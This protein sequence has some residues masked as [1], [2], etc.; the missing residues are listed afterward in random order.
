MLLRPLVYSRSTVTT[1]RQIPRSLGAVSTYEFYGK[2]IKTGPAL[3]LLRAVDGFSCRQPIPALQQVRI[4]GM[5]SLRLLQFH[6]PERRAY[7]PITFSADGVDGAV[8]IFM[9]R[10]PIRALSAAVSFPSPQLVQRGRQSLALFQ[11]LM[12]FRGDHGP[13]NK[14]QSRILKLPGK[15]GACGPAEL[16]LGAD[17]LD[18]ELLDDLFHET[19]RKRIGPQSGNLFPVQAQVRGDV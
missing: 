9:C 4:A 12:P 16:E 10:T 11:H 6:L 5:L 17:G 14:R 13:F 18:A 19:P 1:T 8:M 3:W 2:C 15:R 7:G